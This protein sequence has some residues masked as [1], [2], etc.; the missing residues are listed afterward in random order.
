MH[1]SSADNAY[2]RQKLFR[3]SFASAEAMKSFIN[4]AIAETNRGYTNSKVP[5]TLSLH[6]IVESS[7]QDQTSLSTL[8]DAFRS[9]AS[10]WSAPTQLAEKV[11]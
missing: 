2:Y 4:L 7:I 9:S 6:C 3:D 10:K 8:L 1:S 11:T 5:I